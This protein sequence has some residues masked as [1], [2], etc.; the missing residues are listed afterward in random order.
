MEWTMFPDRW[1]KHF[2]QKLQDE[3]GLSETEAH[4]KLEAWSE[5]LPGLSNPEISPAERLRAR[6]MRSR[7]RSRPSKPKSTTNG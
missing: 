7:G 6:P 2:V 1:R 3:F 5:G 4:S